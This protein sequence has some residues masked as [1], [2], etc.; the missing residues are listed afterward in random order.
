MSRDLTLLL[1]DILESI[2]SIE[3]YTRGMEADAFYEDELVQD[4]VV[5]RLLVI[6]EAAKGVPD[7]ARDK[8]PEVPWRKMAGMRDILIHAYWGVNLERVWTV[9]QEDIPALKKAIEGIL[10]DPA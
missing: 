6:G 5:R 10:D 4:G 8:W 2:E 9:V 1:E 7:E 3:A